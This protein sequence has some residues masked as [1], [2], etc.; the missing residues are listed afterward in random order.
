MRDTA[1]GVFLAKKKRRPSSPEL[2]ARAPIVFTTPQYVDYAWVA[3][4]RIGTATIER[5][6]DVLLGLD[7]DNTRER[8]ILDAWSAGRFVAAQDEQ[9]D[10]IR[11]VRDSLPRGFLEK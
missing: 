6:R 4:D 9:W 11:Q 5:L 1:Q 7:P 8:A 3:H 10:A 2:K